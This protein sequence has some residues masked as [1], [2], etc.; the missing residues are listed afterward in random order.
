MGSEWV[1]I[2]NSSNVSKQRALRSCLKNS[3]SQGLECSLGRAL[4]IGRYQLPTI[5]HLCTTWRGY[6][7]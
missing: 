1:P 6:A 4:G 7:D 5:G 3:F 2:C